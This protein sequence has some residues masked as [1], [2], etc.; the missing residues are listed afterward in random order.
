MYQQ[1]IVRLA[2]TMPAPV[3]C[4]SVPAEHLESLRAGL[5]DIDLQ[6]GRRIDLPDLASPTLAGPSFGL[7]T[8]PDQIVTVRPAP[9]PRKNPFLNSPHRS[10]QRQPRKPPVVVA[11]QEDDA[12][13]VAKADDADASADPAAGSAAVTAEL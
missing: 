9:D 3:L 2:K 5:I 8:K 10:P 11:V 4:A 13:V 6:G 12:S 7:L 1:I